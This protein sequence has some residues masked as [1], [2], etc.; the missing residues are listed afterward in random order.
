MLCGIFVDKKLNFLAATP[1]GLIDNDYIVEI[2]CPVSI[3][4]YK[5]EEA[6]SNKKLN[7]MLHVASNCWKLE[8]KTVSRLLVSNSG[9]I[10][11]NRTKI[12]LLCYMDTKRYSVD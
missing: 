11:C 5:P 2:K 9:A 4:D 12:L 6:F 3:K 8:T 7:C 1:D 10:T